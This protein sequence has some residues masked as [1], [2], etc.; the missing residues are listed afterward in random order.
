MDLIRDK[1]Y[2]TYMDYLDELCLTGEE[3]MACSHPGQCD[4]DCD[5][6][7]KNGTIHDQLRNFSD[8]ALRNAVNAYGT[9][10]E[11]GTDRVTLEQYVLWTAANDIADE[12]LIGEYKD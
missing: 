5:F 11:E 6:Y 2:Y 7:Q 9:E 1:K 10:L 8:E 4:Y 3:V 12:V